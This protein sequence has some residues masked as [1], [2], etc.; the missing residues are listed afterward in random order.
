MRRY[1]VVSGPIQS[2]NAAEISYDAKINIRQLNLKQSFNYFVPTDL[3]RA[4]KLLQK[5]LKQYV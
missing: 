5:G 4:H 1:E 3:I 2:K